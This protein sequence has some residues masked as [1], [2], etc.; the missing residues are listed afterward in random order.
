MSP[1]ISP[2]SLLGKQKYFLKYQVWFNKIFSK[3]YIK[4]IIDYFWI[5]TRSLA[6]GIWFIFAEV[7]FEVIFLS[8]II[9]LLF[10]HI[11][12]T[13][14]YLLT[15]PESNIWKALGDDMNANQ[16]LYS[17]FLFVLL[18]WFMIKVIKNSKEQED[19][20]KTN[21]ILKAIAKKLGVEENDMLTDFE[22]RGKINGR[23]NPK[24][25]L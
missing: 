12:P 16:I 1:I 3:K 14:E 7:L 24:S 4:N 6:Q 15:H 17:I 20:E 11:K 2:D 13:I 25:K 23:K 10:E 18:M 9:Y 22:K 5:L 8:L 21:V 19:K